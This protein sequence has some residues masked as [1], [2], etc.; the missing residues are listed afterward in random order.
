MSIYIIIPKVIHLN[1][2]IAL[3]YNLCPITIFNTIILLYML[4]M[5]INLRL[6]PRRYFNPNCLWV[7]NI[8]K[9]IYLTELQTE[10]PNNYIIP[11]AKIIGS[12]R[13]SLT[14]LKYL[15]IFSNRLD[16]HI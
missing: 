12:W 7:L 13:Y 15:I 4:N 3:K 2:K 6:M 1:R 16:R 5:Y 10:F 8:F 9:G 11:M 14:F